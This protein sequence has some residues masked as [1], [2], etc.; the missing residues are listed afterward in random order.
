[1]VVAIQYL[2]VLLTLA[3]AGCAVASGL[4]WIKSARAKVMASTTSVGGVFG[5]GIHVKLGT[6]EVIDFHATFDEQSK[7]NSRAA[8]TSAAA[9]GL[10]GALALLS[11]ITPT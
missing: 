5:G 1:M 8:Y 10:G 4:Y 3:T 2:K 11:L 9:A 7:F 6:G